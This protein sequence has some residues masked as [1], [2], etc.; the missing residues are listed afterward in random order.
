METIATGR[1]AVWEGGS[2][3]VFDVPGAPDAT[4]RTEMHAHH[5][6]QLTFSLGGNLSFKLEDGV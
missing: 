5:A 3:W 6:F 1:I 2:L 4:S